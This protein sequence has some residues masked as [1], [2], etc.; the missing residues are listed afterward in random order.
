MEAMRMIAKVVV[1][2]VVVGIASIAIGVGPMAAAQEVGDTIR[3]AYNAERGWYPADAGALKK[4]VDDLLA[5]AKPTKL[6]GRPAAVISPHAGYRYSA[7][8][9]AAGYRCLQ[10]SAYR[11]VF[12]LAFSHRYA[13]TYVGVDV[14]G[15]LTAYETPLGRVPI[16]REVCDG[17]LKKRGFS[18]NPGIDRGEHSLELQLPFLQRTLGDFRLVPL[19][20]GRMSDQDYAQAAQA[21]APWIGEDTLLVASSDFTHHGP[22]YNYQPFKDDVAAKICELGD[23]AA[24]PILNCDFDGFAQHLA[25]TGD[26]ICGRG[27]IMLLLRILS[28]QGGAAG[29]VAAFDTSGNIMGDW[30]N[31]VTYQSIVFTRRPGTL[32]E[33]ER[34]EL[35]RL[36]RRTVL[37]QLSGKEPSVPEAGQL[38]AALRAEGACFV[39]LQNRG[40]LRG[41]IGNMEATGPLYQAVIRNAV[42]ACLDRRFASNPVTSREVDELHIEISYL[43]PMKRAQDPDE[44]IV[45]RHGILISLGGRRGVLLPQVAYERGWTRQEFLEQVCRKASLPADAWKRPEAEIYLFEA[46]VFGEPG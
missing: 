7:P 22:N 10:G 14:P 38:P 20:V 28:M 37:A 46:E 23:A 32:D 33:H 24:T 40:R 3:P 16:D 11:R 34:A 18:S 45:G 25:K 17:L 2:F 41:C 12:V 43:T 15:K 19:L 26:T 35:L 13:G 4:Q 8:V 9:A 21:I 30:T 5:R 39:T 29:V 6:G 42:S 27:P 36:A 1:Q 44:V 31:S